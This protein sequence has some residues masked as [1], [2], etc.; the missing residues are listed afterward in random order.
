MRVALRSFCAN[1]CPSNHLR[2]YLLQLCPPVNGMQV[3]HLRSKSAGDLL[4]LLAL[5]HATGGCAR[6]VI[7]DVFRGIYDR[8][9]R[10][11]LRHARSEAV[12]KETR[13]REELFSKE[14]LSQKAVRKSYE[15]LLE[16][17]FICH[18]QAG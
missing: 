13:E 11:V 10:L 9:V 12:W 18:A 1:M 14:L 17:G 6:S 5:W 8:I 16:E 7:Y 3:R 2:M 15:T 4:V